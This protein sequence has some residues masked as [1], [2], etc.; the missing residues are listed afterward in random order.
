MSPRAEEKEPKTETIPKTVKKSFINWIV[1]LLCSALLFGTFTVAKSWADDR[2][3]KR[4]DYDSSNSNLSKQI[5]DA[6]QKREALEAQ[7]EQVNRKLDLIVYILQHDPK[8][9]SKSLPSSL[10][11]GGP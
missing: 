11:S 4:T 5:D 8:I 7:M 3:T 6:R 1:P 2:Y 9:D 10:P